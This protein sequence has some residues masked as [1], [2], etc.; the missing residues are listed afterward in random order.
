MRKSV[1]VEIVNT[2]ERG[3]RLQASSGPSWGTSEN[4][5]GETHLW[6]RDAGCKQYKLPWFIRTALKWTLPGQFHFWNNWTRVSGTSNSPRAPRSLR[7]RDD[8]PACLAPSRHAPPHPGMPLL[9]PA[10]PAPSRHAPPYPG[11]P[12]PHP[13][14]PRCH[15]HSGLP[16]GLCGSH[17]PG[18][19]DA[20]CRSLPEI[21]RGLVCVNKNFSR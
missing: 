2:G 8:F 12:P 6:K 19:S 10:C 5:M 21:G 7:P 20:G 4:P 1:Q 15:V 14:M 16:G 18:S 11:M 9:V 3:K 13:G 17:S